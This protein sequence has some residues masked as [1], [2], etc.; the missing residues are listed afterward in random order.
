MTADVAGELTGTVLT[1][2]LDSSSF[3]GVVC[4]EAM[5]AL[6]DI[7]LAPVCPDHKTHVRCTF[8]TTE[9]TT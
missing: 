4:G 1:R 9:H 7:F 5:E 8:E 3:H 6:R 2:G